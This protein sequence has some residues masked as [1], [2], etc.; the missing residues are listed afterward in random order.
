MEIKPGWYKT[1][2]GRRAYV[3]AICPEPQKVTA[4]GYAVGWVVS[5]EGRWA[6]LAWTDFGQASHQG[7]GCMDLV[8]REPEAEVVQS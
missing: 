3:G 5:S 4:P 1:R 8:S 2:D 6:D 7:P